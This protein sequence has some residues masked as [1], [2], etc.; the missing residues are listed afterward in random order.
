MPPDLQEL[1]TRIRNRDQAAFKSL[2]EMYMQPA[3]R[4]AFRILGNEEEAQETVQDTFVRI[5]QKIDS[6]DPS[7]GFATWMN[8]ILVNLSLDRLRSIRRHPM[9]SIDHTA[10]TLADLRSPDPGSKAEDRDIGLLIRFLADGLPAKQKIVF[11]LR[12]I[13]GLPSGEVEAVTSLPETSVKSNLL[14]ARRRVREQLTRIME[15]ERSIK[16]I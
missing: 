12:D 7:K 16:C 4:L 3:Y 15:K 6:Y 2:V 5:W 14:H 9:V 1:T 13:E 8:R 11:I 10:K